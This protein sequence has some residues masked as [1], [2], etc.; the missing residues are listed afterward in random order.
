M[1]AA[2]VVAAAAL[3]LPRRC[4]VIELLDGGVTQHVQP[5]QSNCGGEV[6][7]WLQTALRETFPNATLV[8]HSGTPDEDFVSG[9][10]SMLVVAVA[11]MQRSPLLLHA[12]VRMPRCILVWRRWRLRG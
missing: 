1:R 4:N 9:A 11:R 5:I 6:T 10:R 12:A 2:R 7:Q 8:R 3:P